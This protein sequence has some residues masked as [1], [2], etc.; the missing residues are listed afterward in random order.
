MN[1]R[2][3]AQS[4]SLIGGHVALDFVNTVG[5]TPTTARHD[6]LSSYEIFLVWSA[7]T[8]TV[9]SPQA[10]RLRRRARRRPADARQG[11]ERARELRSAMYAVFDELRVGAGG[12]A[13]Q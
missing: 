2:E 8:G 1:D 13:A 5:G 11:L 12:V 10:E 6:L 7:R 4:W 3:S 9:D